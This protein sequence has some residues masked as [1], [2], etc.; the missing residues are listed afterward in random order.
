MANDEIKPVTLD[1]CVKNL[2]NQTPDPEVEKAQ[3]IEK[4]LH[5][6]RMKSKEDEGFNI[7]NDDFKV[8]LKKFDSKSPKSMTFYSKVVKNTNSLFSNC[9]AHIAWQFD[10]L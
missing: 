8:V 6:M 9:R 7:N 10:L 3:E 2:S 1:Y 4:H 5:K